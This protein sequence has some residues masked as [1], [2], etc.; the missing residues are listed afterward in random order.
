LSKRETFDLLSCVYVHHR[1][2]ECLRS[3][4]FDPKKISE[5]SSKLLKDMKSD[6]KVPLPIIPSQLRKRDEKAE[7][8]LAQKD[9]VFKVPERKIPPYA[10]MT[11]PVAKEF[12]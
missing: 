7:N 9:N 8:K 5:N 4:I 10:R 11:S 6:F 12:F 3:R 1:K 2:L